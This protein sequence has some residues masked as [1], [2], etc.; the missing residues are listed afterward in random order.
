MPPTRYPKNPSWFIL[1]AFR[2]LFPA[3]FLPTTWLNASKVINRPVSRWSAIIAMELS[4]SSTKNTGSASR[5]IKRLIK[6][7]HLNASRPR[8][9]MVIQCPLKAMPIKLP[10][11][12]CPFAKTHG[13]RERNRLARLLK[14]SFGPSLSLNRSSSAFTQAYMMSLRGNFQTSIMSPS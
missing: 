2:L 11:C 10:L 5:H 7:I 9:T 14:M 4:M 1:P 3:K 6:I 13:G 8:I 12:S